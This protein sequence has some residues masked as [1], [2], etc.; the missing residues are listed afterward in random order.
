[1]T[2][3]DIIVSIIPASILSQMNRSN[4]SFN[5][6]K[7]AASLNKH[8]NGSGSGSEIFEINGN[9]FLNWI[10]SNFKSRLLIRKRSQNIN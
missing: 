5:K 9:G 10:T 6:L 2:Q 3:N 4:N 7:N 8:E 1:M